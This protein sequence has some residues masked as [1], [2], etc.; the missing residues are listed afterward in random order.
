MRQF[1]ASFPLLSLCIFIAFTTSSFGAVQDRVAG[2]VDSA[3]MV[4][5]PHG[6]PLKAKAEFDQGIVETSF[7]LNHVTMFAVPSASQQKALDQLLAQQQDKKSASHHKWLTPE[8]YA[9]RFGLSQNDISRITAWLKSQGLKVLSVARGR[10]F[11]VFSGSAGQIQ[12]ALRTEIHRYNVNGEM[13]FA[14]STPASI[15]ASL[16]GVVAAFRGLDD[17]RP[18]ALGIRRDARVP[19]PNYN[20]AAEQLGDLIAPGD[21]ATIYDINTLYTGG[22]DGTGQKLVVAGQTDVYLAD[23][24]DFRSGFG[25]SAVSCAVDANGVITSS[26]AA[27]NDPHFKVVFAGTDPGVSPGDL[28]ESDLDLEWAGAVARGAQIIFV[29]SPNAFDS[30]DYA[31]DNNLAPVISLSYGICELGAVGL[32]ETE[33]KQGNLEGITIVNSSGDTGVAECDGNGASIATGGLAVSYPASSPEVT[34]VG[35]SS[36][37]LANFSSTY[38]NVPT[39]NPTDG[40]TAKSYI[41]EIGWNDDAEIAEACAQQPTNLFCEDNGITSALTAQEAIGIS[42]SGGGVSNCTTTTGNPP[43]CTGGFAQPSW[44]AS[45]SIPSQAAGRFSPD[46]SFLA[47]PN[48][49]GYIFCT[50]LSEL[51]DAGTANSSCSP[52]GSAGITNGLDL[53][54]PSIIGGTSASA[55]VF[56]GMV[57]LLNQYLDSAGQ[58]NLNPTLYTLAATQPNSVFHKVTSSSNVVYCQ[59]GT[60]SGQPAALKCPGTSG[61][62]SFGYQASNADPTTGYN[63]VSGLGSVDLNNLALAMAPA[64]SGSFTLSSNVSSVSV[65][66]GQ[67]GPVT[68]TITPDPSTGFDGTLNFTNANCSGLPSETTCNFSPPSITFSGTAPETVTLNI[69]TTAPISEMRSPFARGGRM[70]YAALLPGFFGI[71]LTMGSRKRALAAGARLLGLIFMLGIS[72]LW[73]GSCGGN[74]TSSNGDPGTP[75]GSSTVTVTVGS[76]STA[77]VLHIALTVTAK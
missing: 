26:V 40:G 66:Q 70:F 23:I 72:T 5:L 30:Y 59:A 22:F 51:D 77:Q 2:T 1:R 60:P 38:W 35:G 9:D 57:T 52:G 3:H 34:G 6:V 24:A 47:T 12:S 61:T 27:C 54:N 7:P 56:A 14:N 63:L 15:P 19:R 74:A 64:V 48:F 31:I 4:Q 62:G 41:P 21:I 65:I 37:D 32:D 71:F 33:L 29:T 28:S 45:L 42:S 11:I 10:D 55:P 36:I 25:L 39:T 73:L 67:T 75:P 46:V 8:Q 68:I 44:Q 20:A 58:G 69:V 76:G 53:Q 17:F 50:Q 49:P 43:V 13:H 18:K 16:T